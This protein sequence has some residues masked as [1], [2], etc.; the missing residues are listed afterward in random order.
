MRIASLVAVFLL[1]LS[2]VFAQVIPGTYIGQFL[3]PDGLPIVF[4]LDIQGEGAAV[5]WTIRNGEER[6]TIDRIRRKGD[7]VWV[8]MPFFESAFRLQI[9]GQRMSGIWVKAGEQQPE[10]LQ[11]V[12]IRPGQVKFPVF[13]GQPTTDISG[14]WKATFI[15]PNGTQRPAIAAFR[16]QGQQLTGTFLTPTGDYRYLE[17]TIQGDTLQLSCFDGSHAFYF[18]ARLSGKDQLVDGVFAAGGTNCEPWSA[19]RDAAAILDRSAARMQ[20]IPGSPPLQFR[21][22]DLDSNLVSLEDPRYRGKVLILQIMGSWCPNCMDET[23]F[24]SNFYRQHRSRG[25]EVIGLAYEYSADFQRSRRSLS[26]FRDFF[27][28]TYPMLIT[29][30]TSADTLRTQKTLP[31]FTPIRAFP[32]TIFLGKDGRVRHTEV[33]YAGPATGPAHEVFRKELEERVEALLRE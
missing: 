30:V 17:G 22:P 29:G 2:C 26:K 8:D 25:V 20:W 5:R 13:Q 21:F 33:G 9:H 19:T 24:L 11:R 12:E 15:R 31:G 14:R 27:E 32:T 1:T 18:G 6:I 4:H 3:R 28:V 10:V 7:S 16:Q 23:A